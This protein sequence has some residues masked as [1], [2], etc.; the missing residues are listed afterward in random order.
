VRGRR[1]VSAER[2][3]M[4]SGPHEADLKRQ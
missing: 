3:A 4:V 1:R 2:A